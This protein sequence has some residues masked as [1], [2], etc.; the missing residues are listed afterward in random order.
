MISTVCPHPREIEPV[1]ENTNRFNQF[2]ITYE[3]VTESIGREGER[4]RQIFR[5]EDSF[6]LGRTLGLNT[7]KT[8]RTQ[9]RYS[10]FSLSAGCAY[11][12]H[13][14]ETVVYVCF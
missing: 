3:G 6:D 11:Q 4:E 2:L 1:S 12:L 8:S 5:G 10:V 9:V 14:T 7:Y 13:M